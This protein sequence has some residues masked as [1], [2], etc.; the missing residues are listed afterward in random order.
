MIVGF[1]GLGAMGGAIASRLVAGGQRMV[2]HDKSPERAKLFEGKA[3]IAVSSRAV[4][5]AADGVFT[6]LTSPQTYEEAVFGPQ[7]IIGGSKIR[8][9]IHA[10]TSESALLE[11]LETAFAAQG[12]DV[13]DAPVTGGVA[14]GVNGTLTVMVAGKRK[15]F[16]DMMPLF[17]NYGTK[18]VHVSDRVGAAQRLKHVNSMLSAANLAIACEA[19]LVAHKAGLSLDATLDVLNNGTGQSIATL[20]KIPKQMFTR[21]FNHG[22]AI[23]LMIKD[24]R[25]FIGAAH[26]FDVPAPMCEAVVSAFVKAADELG[27][28]VDVTA[29][30]RSIERAA[31]FE[32]PVVEPGATTPA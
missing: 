31:G 28:K 11:R 15:V 30:M 16:D 23:E 26:D 1:V 10:G 19:L 25:A 4:A 5:D 22:G 32:L 13:L 12:V 17:L 24:I 27:G 20:D 21:A 3:Q 6:C 9:Y 8:T 7:G 29:V 14:R 18:V 2:V